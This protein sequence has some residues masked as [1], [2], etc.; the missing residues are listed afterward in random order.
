MSKPTTENIEIC[1][2]QAARASFPDKRGQI[3]NANI[4]LAAMVDH[5]RTLESENAAMKAKI[6]GQLLAAVESAYDETAEK[7]IEKESNE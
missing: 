3:K 5:I 2:A 1:I 4:E 7:S 6:G